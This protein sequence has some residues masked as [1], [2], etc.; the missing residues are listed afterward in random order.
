MRVAQNLGTK[1][2]LK[3]IQRAIGE[4]P[5]LLQPDAIGDIRWVSPL[6]TDDFA[7]YRDEDFLDV[8]GLSHLGASLRAFWPRRGPQWDAL[9]VTKTGVVLVEAKAHIGE[10]RSPPSQAGAHSRAKITAAFGRVQPTF[11]VPL[12]TDWMGRFY[13]Y[14]N[15]L[16]HLAW[17]VS[18]G[19]DAHLLFVS[20]INDDAMLGPSSPNEWRAAFREAD[21]ALALPALHELSERIHHVFPDVTMLTVPK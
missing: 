17:L 2:S 18:E 15:R 11:G 19:V 14:A 9:G 7:E 5:D 6:E 16:A 21:A 13:Q 4:R 20:F 12:H 10:F 1:G 8:V 3:W